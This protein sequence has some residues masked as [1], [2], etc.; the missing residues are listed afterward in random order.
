[1]DKKEAMRICVLSP[2][3]WRYRLKERIEI[4]KTIWLRP[5]PDSGRSAA[6]TD[7]ART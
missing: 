5:K 2:V 7:G 6:T 4:F 1:M 3:Y